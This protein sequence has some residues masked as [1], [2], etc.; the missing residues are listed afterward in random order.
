[1]ARELREE[2]QSN[3]LAI[4]ILRKGGDGPNES[5]NVGAGVW[6]P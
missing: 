6:G 3:G 5:Q 4:E 1:L 2:E